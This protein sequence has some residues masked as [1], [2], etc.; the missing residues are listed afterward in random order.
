MSS[1]S[2]LSAPSQ[3]EIKTIARDMAREDPFLRA[4]MECMMNKSS[5]NRRG[6]KV[7]VLYD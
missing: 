3:L 6:A 4:K 1:L 2:F 5:K 7:G